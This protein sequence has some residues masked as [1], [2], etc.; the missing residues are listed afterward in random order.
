VSVN[1]WPGLRSSAAGSSGAA[2]AS[3]N[4]GLDHPHRSAERAR[5]RRGFLGARRH[6]A[7]R[8]RDRVAAEQ[9]LRL[10]FVQIH[11]GCR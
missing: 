6:L 10:V 5:G 4:L 9:I 11:R 7:R 1:F 2:A 3:V 8:D